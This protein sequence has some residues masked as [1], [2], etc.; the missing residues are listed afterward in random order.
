MSG[1][2]EPKKSGAEKDLSRLSQ[3]RQIEV[4]FWERKKAKEILFYHFEKFGRSRSWIAEQVGVS[5]YYIQVAMN[6]NKRTRENDS[7]ICPAY[8]IKKIIEWGKHE[9]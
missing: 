8:V 6:M 1:R 5:C 2:V 9:L 4:T 3:C 7:F